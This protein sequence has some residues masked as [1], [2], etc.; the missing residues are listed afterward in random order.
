MNALGSGTIKAVLLAAWLAAGAP[1]AAQDGRRVT[2]VDR[3]LI[4]GARHSFDRETGVPGEGVVRVAARSE[5][6]D[7]WASA[8]AV[9]VVDAL[10]A[11]ERINAV[12]WARAARPTRVPALFQSRAEP[13]AAFASTEIALT[14]AWQ[15]F[16]VSGVA[17]VALAAGSQTFSVQLGQA[18]AE[19]SFGPVLLLSGEAGPARIDA[20][21][22]AFRPTRLA[23]DVRIASDPGVVL[24]GT[25]RTPSARG[26]GPFPVVLLL[27]GG[28]AS[29]RG[30]YDLLSD[31]LL[32][33][34]IATLEYDKRGLG[35]STGEFVDAIPL[36]ERDAIAAIAYLRA[37]PDIDGRRIALLG[38]SQGAVVG[39]AIAARDPQ[40]AAVVMLAGPVGPRAEPFFEGLRSNL[41]RA[42]MG[43]A[44]IERVAAATGELMEARLRGA[45][46]AELSPLREALIQGFVAGGFPRA[47]AEGAAGA[48][49]S[50]VLVSMYDVATDRALAAVRVPVLVLFG[51]MDTNVPTAQNM[52]AARTAVAGNPDATV[53]ELPGLN[54]GFQRAEAV[55]AQQPGNLVPPVSAPEAI[56]LIGDWLDTRLNRSR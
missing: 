2:E 1:A 54:H 55:A 36:M 34:G 16:T 39:P 26:A 23:R 31:R 49:E 5:P 35:E 8:L 44:A 18:G 12:F 42:G 11:G 15:R 53:R 40:I 17:P 47:Q 30:V 13:Y 24:A 33:E 25:L 37:R 9:P 32:A 28:G 52:P 20:A 29:Q 43:E 19:V 50:P 21:A 48:M 46:E 3:L 27:A 4:Y 6:G 22:A 51:S 14:P 38:L 45:S 41:A 10:G 56:T 7:P